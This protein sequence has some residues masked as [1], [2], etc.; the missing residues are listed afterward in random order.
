MCMTTTVCGRRL[1]DIGLIFELI[2]RFKFDHE[3]LNAMK[4]K[5]LVSLPKKFQE[6]CNSERLKQVAE[7]AK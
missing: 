5:F 6:D 1:N 3:S 7:R 2:F 4:V